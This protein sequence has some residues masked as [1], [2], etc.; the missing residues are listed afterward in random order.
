MTKKHNA[1]GSND[2]HTCSKKKNDEMWYDPL[3]M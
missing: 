3:G 1:Q 2:F